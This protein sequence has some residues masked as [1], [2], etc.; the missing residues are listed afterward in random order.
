VATGS[1]DCIQSTSKIKTETGLAAPKRRTLKNVRLREVE[2]SAK[3]MITYTDHKNSDIEI[4]VVLIVLCLDE[5]CCYQC[6]RT[7]AE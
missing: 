1:A 2:V 7:V 4:F 3:Q 5:T 6:D